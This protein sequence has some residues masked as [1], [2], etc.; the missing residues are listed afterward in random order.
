M[1]SKH[2]LD[3]RK[4]FFESLC[5]QVNLNVSTLLVFYN[6]EHSFNLQHTLKCYFNNLCSG[7]AYF[8]LDHTFSL[9]SLLSM[10]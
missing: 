3:V 1:Q 5:F 7:W 9:D 6:S 2:V 8:A 10:D 4:I